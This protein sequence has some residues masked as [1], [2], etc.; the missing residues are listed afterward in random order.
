MRRST[1]VGIAVGIAAAAVAFASPPA[2]ASISQW[3]TLDG[4][5]G[6]VPGM[7]A[8]Q[9]RWHWGIDVPS[10]KEACGISKFHIGKLRGYALFLHGR[11]GA[12]FFTHGALTPS[13]VRIGSPLSLAVHFYGKRL[14]TVPGSGSYFMTR[15]LRHPWQLRF[16]VNKSNRIVLIGFGD[17]T[18]HIVG[19]CGYT[20]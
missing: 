18:V 11:F 7:T 3:V 2:P 9:V 8:A 4:V 13:G 1:R 10:A 6:V 12:V 19:G 15:I 16:D 14:K 5:G 17:S 20:G